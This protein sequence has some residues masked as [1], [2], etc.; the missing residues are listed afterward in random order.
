V[1]SRII[2]DQA[3]GRVAERG[4]LAS[5]H[6][7]FTLLRVYAR[8]NNQRLTDVA[9][10]VINNTLDTTPVLTLVPGP[11]TGPRL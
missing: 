5:A 1:A 10:A 8:H 4:Q 7:A 2:I 6:D 11:R 9:T 3:K